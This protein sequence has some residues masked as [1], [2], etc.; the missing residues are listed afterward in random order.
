MGTVAA[1]LFP[2]LPD[3]AAA[4][5]E[6]SPH[7]PTTGVLNVDET[8]ASGRVLAVTTLGM[9]LDTGVGQRVVHLDQATRVWKETVLSARA[10]ELG[11]AV[12][13]SGVPQPDGSLVARQV[14]ANIIRFSG[15]VTASDPD[16]VYLRGPAG[17]ASRI[18]YSAYVAVEDASGGRHPDGIA[19][20]RVGLKI[21]GVGVRIKDG[22][23]RATR[24]WLDG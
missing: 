13:V 5:V 9:V 2:G 16:A 7:A 23:R 14:W 22:T 18:A 15:V 8:F 3:V 19:A 24:L 17:A 12:D 6:I 20:I 11:D 10:L 4:V 21:G 1:L